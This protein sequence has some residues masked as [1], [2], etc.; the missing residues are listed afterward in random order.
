MLDIATDNAIADHRTYGNVG[1]QHR[2]FG[3]LRR[4][5][6]V[7]WTQPQGYRPFWTI[8]K[9]ADIIEIERQADRFINAPR[10]KLLSIDFESKVREAM[11]GK[12]MLV[13]ALPQMDNPD[14]GK[15]QKL[16]HAWFQPRHIRT[17][18]ERMAALAKESVDR[19][20]AMGNQCDFYNDIAIYYP[21]R[22]LMTIL[23]LPRNDEERLLKITQAYFGGGDPEMQKGSD[24][25]DATI[26]Y[27]DYFKDVA[28]ERRKNPQDDVATVIATSE[29]DGRPIEDFEAYSYYVALASAGHDTTS[30][31][32][33]GG[34]L[35]LIE[36]A[37]AMARLQR[38]PE[39]LSD[40]AEEMVRWV[41]PVK[42]FF[43]TATADYDIRGKTI[44]AG[45][46]LLLSYPSGNRDEEAFDRP[47]QFIPD[48]SPNRHLGYGFGIHACIGRHLAKAEIVAFFREFLCRIERVELAGASAW[49]ETSFLGGVKRLPIRYS[50]R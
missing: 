42:H 25:I 29:I 14:H 28:R 34:L 32:I 38:D 8:T 3:E 4:D 45:D 6:P 18:S 30:A 5:D 15:Y 48:R 16:T 19:L 12:P 46:S 7:H 21:L 9:Y 27:V 49:T 20:V 23:G 17:L 35:A 40:A 50:V 31:T 47:L 37:D 1:L 2:L 44:R 13:R 33:A 24:L 22:V 39:L 26:A 10:T 36:N 43:R 41:S 11:S